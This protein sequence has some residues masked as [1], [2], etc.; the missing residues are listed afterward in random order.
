MTSYAF[1]I[2]GEPIQ[3]RG[4]DDHFRADVD[5]VETWH[6]RAALTIWGDEERSALSIVRTEIPAPLPTV[7]VLCA[8]IDAERDRRMAEDF[9]HDFGETLAFDDERTLLGPGQGQE[10]PAGLRL[11]QMQP[12]PDQRNWQALQGAALTAVVSGAPET[13]LPMRAEDNWNIQTTALQV[14]AVLSA[15]TAKGAELLFHGGALKSQQ[16]AAYPV[17]IDRTAGWP[18]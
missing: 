17:I 10:I 18:S 16:R 15:M 1:T 3:F 2:G 14:L 12:D 13:V 9:A 5:G 11:L 6:P 4:A 7:E 8:L